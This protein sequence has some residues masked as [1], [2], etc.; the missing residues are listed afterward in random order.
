MIYL[1][2]IHKRPS[3]VGAAGYPLASPVLRQLDQLTL[4]QPV[5]ILCGENGSGKTTLMELMAAGTAAQTIGESGV[6]ADKA[7]LF[8]QAAGQFR[9]VMARRPK[10]SF[11]F[12]AEDFS[13]YL[14]QRRA[15]MADARQALN[16]I[17]GAYDERSTLARSLARM[18]H[19]RTLGEMAGQYE[20]DLLAS[21]HGEGFLSF[22]GG[23][24]VQGGLY[25]L[26]EPEGA[27]SYANQL[28][29]MALI[30]RAV[31]S[32]GQVIMATHSPVLAA[33]PNAA[34]LDVSAGGIEA[35]RYE[36]LP[37]VQFLSHFL[38]HREAILN[39]LELPDASTLNE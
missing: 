3:E 5:T 15:M 36:Q 21:S 6:H 20:R 4:T 18:P 23:R 30:G 2:E 9:F 27:L 26:D 10:R 19:A 25:L 12:T 33:Y 17:D 38:K 16:E 11:Y 13:R 34:L 14:D 1:R 29:L 24:L 28:S 31:A 22:F 35:V 32:G 37:G 39:Q 7:R 8:R